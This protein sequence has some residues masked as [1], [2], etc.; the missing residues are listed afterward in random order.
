MTGHKLHRHLDHAV[1]HTVHGRPAPSAAL[2]AEPPPDCVT[3]TENRFLQSIWHVPCTVA[4]YSGAVALAVSAHGAVAVPLGASS[5]LAV[6]SLARGPV[7]GLGRG[8]AVG[9]PVSR[10]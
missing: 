6:A 10:G 3:V 9:T 2:Q 7:A 8:Y 4:A 1:T 5:G